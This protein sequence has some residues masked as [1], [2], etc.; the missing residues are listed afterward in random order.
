MTDNNQPSA[1]FAINVL[2]ITATFP[3]LI[4]PWLINQLVQ[5]IKNGGLNKILA[6]RAEL[7]VYSSDV[8]S[9]NLIECSQLVPEDRSGLLKNLFSGFA[10]ATGIK[11][12]FYGIKAYKNVLFSQEFTLKEKIYSLFLIPNFWL[13]EIDVIHSHSEMAGN[14]FLPLVWAAKKPFV[15]TFHGLPPAGVVPITATQRKRY[16]DMSSVILVNTEFAKTQYMSLG[17]DGGKIRI[18]PQG[19]NLNDFPFKVRPFPA[20]EINVLTVGRFHPDKGQKYAL[21]AVA[22]MIKQGANLRYRMVGNGPDRV[23]LEELSKE[24]GIE[25]KVDFYSGLTDEELRA[26]YAGSHIFILPSLKSEDG[27]HEETQGVVL[28][29]AQAAG[30]ITIATNTGGIPECI[31]NGV[32]GFLVD[33]RSADAI[34]EALQ[35]V[36]D[37]KQQWDVIQTAGRAWVE[38]NYD[39]DVIGRKINTLYKEL[40]DNK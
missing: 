37:K 6:R 8:D 39:I 14:K 28:Q 30:L 10:S 21:T 25:E 3:S 1:S 7:T 31:D 27:F 16:T 18:L 4:Q 9:Y 23:V 19:I 32:S 11:T 33:D 12:F 13:G 5:I 2:T 35:L 38:E 22:T 26:I 29:E 20:G 24:L 34:A 36:I 15:I 40:V 17:V